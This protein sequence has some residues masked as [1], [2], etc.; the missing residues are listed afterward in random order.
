MVDGG[1]WVVDGLSLPIQVPFKSGREATASPLRKTRNPKLETRRKQRNFKRP[2]ERHRLRAEGRS[3]KSQIKSVT[4]QPRRCRE[5]SVRVGQCSSVFVRVRPPPPIER[6]PKGQNMPR[7]WNA[8]FGLLTFSF[9]LFTFPFFVPLLLPE[10]ARGHAVDRLQCRYRL[11]QRGVSCRLK[12]ELDLF[13]RHVL[14]RR[15]VS[16]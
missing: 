3:K 15:K 16:Y 10:I 6:L 9:L 11:Q 5:S 13:Q 1:W 12:V 7:A 4:V 14:Q 2:N 8:S